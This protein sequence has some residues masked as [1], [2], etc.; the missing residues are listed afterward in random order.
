MFAD[1]QT[2]TIS[3]VAQAMVKINQDKYSSEYLLKT[4]LDEHRLTIRNTSYFDKKRQ[5]TISRHNVELVK[6]I[7]P[8]AP[9]TTSVIRKAYFVLENQ[10]GDNPT[11]IVALT[12]GLFNWALASSSAALLKLINF[13]S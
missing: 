12:A 3:S 1:P 4:T 5:M 6:T 8:V 13:E 7:Y 10:D 11:D 2:V 9:S